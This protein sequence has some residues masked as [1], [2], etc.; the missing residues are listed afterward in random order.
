MWLILDFLIK[1]K[2]WLVLVQEFFAILWTNHHIHSYFCWV[3]QLLYSLWY[4][5]I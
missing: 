5:L 1:L 4:L 3:K 2:I